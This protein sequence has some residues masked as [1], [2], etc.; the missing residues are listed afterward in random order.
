MTR[1][2]AIY[3]D[4][5]T[6][7][8][9]VQLNLLQRRV[10]AFAMLSEIVVVPFAGKERTNKKRLRPVLRLGV[11]LNVVFIV[12]ITRRLKAELVLNFWSP[13][14][15]AAHAFRL[16]LN[17]PGFDNCVR[18]RGGNQSIEHKVDLRHGRLRKHQD[19]SDG[20]CCS[21]YCCCGHLDT[22]SLYDVATANRLCGKGSSLLRGQRQSRERQ[23]QPQFRR[24]GSLGPRLARGRADGHNLLLLLRLEVIGGLL[25]GPTTA[26]FGQPC[27]PLR[28][29]KQTGPSALILQVALQSPYTLAL[30]IH[31][32]IGVGTDL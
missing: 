26:R 21:C 16:L 23:R 27:S 14:L 19:R 24:R 15:C 30:L 10:S 31:P 8:V 5:R 9:C 25:K 12:A 20:C 1:T 4:L 17:F 2:K 6:N 3:I 28:A 32:L 11:C 13:N 29:Q 22:S 7:L 18:G